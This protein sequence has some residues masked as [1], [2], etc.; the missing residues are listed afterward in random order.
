M[1][2]AVQISAVIGN[3]LPGPGT[4]YLNQTLKFMAPVFIG[5]TLTTRV[6]VISMKDGKPIATLDTVCTNQDGKVVLQGEA[7]VMLPPEVRN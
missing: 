3:A 7:V 5:D 4:V 1:I 6:T 2:A